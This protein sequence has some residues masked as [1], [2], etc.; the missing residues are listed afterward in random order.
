MK[1]GKMNIQ[2]H[3]FVLIFFLLLYLFFPTRNSSIDAWFYA[4]CVKHAEHLFEPHHLLYNA[5]AFVI[6][7]LLYA[8]G[9]SPDVL[10]LMK[11]INALTATGI[12]IVLRSTLLTVNCEKNIVNYYLVLAG[13]CFAIGRYA[14]ENETYIIPVLLSMVATF[15]FIRF[16]KQRQLYTIGLSG[17]FA[18]LAC[19]YHQIHVFWW[20]GLWIG[21][22]LIKSKWKTIAFYTSLAVLVPFVYVMVIYFYKNQPV[23][24]NNISAFVLRDFL[25]GSVETSIQSKH[26]LLTG[27]N[28]IRSFIQVHGYMFAM[29][30]KHVFYIIPA[31]VSF[32]LFVTTLFFLRRTKKQHDKTFFRIGAVLVIVFCLHW[33]FALF[34]VGNAEFMVMLPL[35][36]IVAVGIFFKLQHQVLAAWAISLLVWNISYGLLPNALLDF[37]NSGEISALVLQHPN[38]LFILKDNKLIENQMYY[39]TGIEER[40]QLHKAPSMLKGQN[41]IAALHNKIES[42]YKTDKQVFT[43]CIDYPGVM[44]RRKIIENKGDVEFFSKYKLV[45]TDTIETYTGLNIIYKVSRLQ[46]SENAI[47]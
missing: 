28:T 10:L 17:F 1:A 32:A 4:G 35:L 37:K 22:F 7:K 45:A 42:Y 38:D 41:E 47:E 8:L 14:T 12:L 23:S 21:L 46:N 6:Y 40:D 25:K 27:L 3:W 24:L 39:S 26:F 33:L 34:S 19:L 20:F 15:Y 31:I 2:K 29:I 18:S 30:K 16:Y 9:F 44:S 43:D 13:S 5:T 11:S 36:A